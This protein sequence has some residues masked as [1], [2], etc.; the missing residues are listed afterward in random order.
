M[1]WSEVFV[2]FLVCHLAGDFLLQTEFQAVNK[3]GGLGADAR[4]RRALRL[5]VL[6][7]LLPFVP[8]TL[9]IADDEQTGLPWL[10]LLLLM[11]THFVQ[12]DG[13]LLKRYVARVKKTDP[14]PGSP[15]WIA[16]DQSFHI[17]TLFFLA[18]V[19]AA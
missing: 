2:L 8:A 4:H 3:H 13:R 19:A 6:T 18:L 10:A 15:L 12:D 9:V 16:I 5:H 14:P 17:V 7:Y 1:S 11:V